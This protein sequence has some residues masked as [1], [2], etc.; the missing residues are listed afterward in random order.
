MERDSA[1][2]IAGKLSLAT[3]VAAVAYFLI[4]RPLQ[5]RWG[6][7]DEEVARAMPGDEIMAHPV[8]DATRAVTI[9]A[10]AE[11]IWPWLVQIGYRR[12][13]WYGLDLIDNDAVPSARQIIPELQNLKVGDP[14]PISPIAQQWVIAIEPNRYLLTKGGDDTTWLWALNPIDEGHTRL[15]WR[16]RS[17]PYNWTSWYIA[18]QLL[19]D[20]VDIVAVRENLLG[21]KERVEG[22]PPAAPALAYVELGLWT[23]AFVGY[24]AAE[25]GIVVGH[26]W[27]R[28]LL[29][30]AGTAL[31]TIGVVI[32]KPPIP[33]DLV[34]A[35]G[36]WAGVAW[37]YWSLGTRL[38]KFSRPFMRLRASRN[39]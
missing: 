30:A 9:D 28:A 7:T 12:A 32:A 38:S 35:V 15:I 36:A 14:M 18:P 39:G 17:A 3:A 26:D 22:R 10:P 1:V 34:A 11:A 19:T 33:V 8:F 27:R 25:V 5:L 23:V 6:A 16:M 2:R 13:G 37:A 24:L 29:A 21:I 4:Y 20:A 31:G